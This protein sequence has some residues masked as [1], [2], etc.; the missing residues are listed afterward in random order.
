MKYLIVGFG[1][2]G[3]L[4][5]ERITL[6]FPSCQLLV[7]EPDSAKTAEIAERHGVIDEDATAFLLSGSSLE[8][9]DIVIP[10]VPFHLAA[11][12]ISAGAGRRKVALPPGLEEQVPHPYP[13]DPSNLFCSRADFVCPDDCP[14]GDC[15]TVTG[16]PREP[17]YSTLE[18]LKAPGWN[19][20]VL[21]SF[22]ILPGV[23]GY[24]LSDLRSL[25]SN[26]AK[27]L[28]IIVTACKCH[29]VLTGVEVF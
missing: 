24:P 26:V 23:G 27:G 3:R 20:W 15:C 19:V 25:K 28:H 2:F 22:Q 16:L 12:Y 14:E 10:M 29:G 17:L 11:T 1:K 13:L 9:D 18:S 6:N 7:V 21:R 5:Y 8:A 4:A